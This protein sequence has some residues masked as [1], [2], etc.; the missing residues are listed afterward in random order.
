MTR[1]LVYLL[2]RADRVLDVV[3]LHGVLRGVFDLPRGEMNFWW[4][5]LSAYRSAH[6]ELS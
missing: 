2:R 1:G 5:V 3:A 6:C 4:W